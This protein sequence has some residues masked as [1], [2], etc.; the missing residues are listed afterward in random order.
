MLIAM[1]EKHFIVFV[2]IT[3]VLSILVPAIAQPDTPTPTPTATPPY[4]PTLT[5][6]MRSLTAPTLPPTTDPL[7]LGP[8]APTATVSYP[9]PTPDNRPGPTPNG[10][11]RHVRVP[12]LMYHYVSVPPEDADNYRVGLSVTPGEFRRQM[13]Y[14][15]DNGY[16]PVALDEVIYALAQ[17]QPLP[18]N[19]V[20]ISFDDGYADMYTNAFPILQE[21]GF[22]A[23]FFVVTEWIDQANP[24]YLS[25]PQVQ[26]MAAAGMRIE[27]HTKTHPDLT[28]KPYDF[29][30]YEILGSIESIEAYTGIRPRFLSYPAGAY[31]EYLLE[32]LPDFALW[33]AVTTEA[34]TRHYQDKSYTLRRVR[35]AS[36]TT[37]AQ[38]AGFL[39]WGSEGD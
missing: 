3:T 2:T 17:G 11:K 19:P 7:A 22:T 1:K 33:G 29:I 16:H 14:M 38:F 23:T 13:Q 15:A 5:P 10:M 39:E 36:D 30:V 24:N 34:G 31:D 9:S 26:E 6:T 12:I 20:V 27:T 32:Q 18:E 25:W 4:K 37:L 21:F 8:A 28:D 35:I